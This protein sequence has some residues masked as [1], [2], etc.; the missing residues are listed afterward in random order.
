LPLGLPEHTIYEVVVGVESQMLIDINLS[1]Q[2]R[3]ITS[4]KIDLDAN[5]FDFG[6]NS[7]SLS[8][9]AF[10]QLKINPTD[11]W[12]EP[13]DIVNLSSLDQ[14]GIDGRI[15]VAFYGNPLRG[16]LS[17]VPQTGEQHQL[18]VWFDRSV[19]VDGPLTAEPPI[20]DAY[21]IHL[22]L[23]AVAQCLELMGKPIGEALKLRIAKGEQQWE[24]YVRQS[25]QQGQIRKPSSHPRARGRSCGGFQRPG[26]GWL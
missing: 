20:E 15:A 25:G 14:S 13:V 8:I 2:N 10:A 16:R 5:S 21:L 26:G 6:L 23:Q 4:K 3:R 7:T 24:R 1:D 12:W 18:T 9:P 19:D 17:W 22:K 11:T